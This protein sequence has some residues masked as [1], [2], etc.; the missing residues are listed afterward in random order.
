MNIAWRVRLLP[1]RVGLPILHTSEL[2][3]VLTHGRLS[4]LP[5]SVNRRCCSR[6]FY[7]FAVRGNG[8]ARRCIAEIAPFA[9]S[10]ALPFDE[11]THEL[12]PA[13]AASPSRSPLPSSHLLRFRL[14]PAERQPEKGVHAVLRLVTFL[15]YWSH[16]PYYVQFSTSACAEM[17]VSL[18]YP[19]TAERQTFAKLAG[20]DVCLAS[21]SSTAE[22]QTFA[23]RSL[24]KS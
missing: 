15:S 24:K 10:L 4:F 7:P 2:S 9:P 8:S 22:R 23:K 19:S 11:V 14:A 1:P 12:S 21:V 18:L 13:G 16:M 17:S 6:F 3:L 20:T 5:L